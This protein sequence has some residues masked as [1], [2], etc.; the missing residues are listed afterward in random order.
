MRIHLAAIV[1]LGLA[2]TGCAS[3]DSIKSLEP[4]FFGTT[5]RTAQDYS[6]CVVAAWKG[7]GM[8][9]TRSPIQDGFQVSASSSISAEAVLS[10]ITYR[11]KTD[12]KMS[13]RMAQ[14]GRSLID[15][16]NL[17]M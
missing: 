6:E 8:E 7:Q 2:V 13:T 3:V 14:R 4:S 1:A 11:G 10:V 16:A 9:V 15:A 12:V 17:C 5:P